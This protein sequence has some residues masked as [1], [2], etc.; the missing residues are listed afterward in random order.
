MRV[1]VPRGDE[2]NALRGRR[3]CFGTARREV[4]PEEANDTD[5]SNASLG[6]SRNDRITGA[7]SSEGDPSEEDGHRAAGSR[8]TARPG[9]SDPGRRGR[10]RRRVE[11]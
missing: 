11:D 1:R 7:S 6:E 2:E 10:A 4:G 5:A 3:D 8:S 9:A